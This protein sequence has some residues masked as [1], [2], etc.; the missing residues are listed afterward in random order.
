MMVFCSGWPGES[1]INHV[2][3]ACLHY[4]D[5]IDGGSHCICTAVQAFMMKR[6]FYCGTCMLA[7]AVVWLLIASVQIMSEKTVRT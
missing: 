1:V 5:I 2:H 3:T 7:V 6:R 4:R